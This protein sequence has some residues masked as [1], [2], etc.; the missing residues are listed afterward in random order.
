MGYLTIK[1]DELFLLYS[2]T[3]INLKFIMSSERSLLYASAKKYKL[4]DSIY[5]KL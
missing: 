5:I 1:R 3:W 4:Y 2:V